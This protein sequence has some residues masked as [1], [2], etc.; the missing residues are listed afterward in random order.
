VLRLER[1]R[2]WQAALDSN[3]PSGVFAGMGL[4]PMEYGKIVTMIYLKARAIPSSCMLW[5]MVLL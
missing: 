1:E 2:A 3:N 4:P 5:M